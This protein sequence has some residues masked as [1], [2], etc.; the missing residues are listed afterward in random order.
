MKPQKQLHFAQLYPG[1]KVPGVHCAF[2]L[3][4]QPCRR[5]AMQKTCFALC[6]TSACNGETEFVA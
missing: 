3:H 6:A 2:L 1:N 4:S 5:D